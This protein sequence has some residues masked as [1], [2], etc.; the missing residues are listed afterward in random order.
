LGAS[1][2]IKADGEELEF[3]KLRFAKSPQFRMGKSESTR[4]VQRRS[5]RLG[6]SSEKSEIKRARGFFK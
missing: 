1:G 6:T 3:S 2:K 5:F 4:I